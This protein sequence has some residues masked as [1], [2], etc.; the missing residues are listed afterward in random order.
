MK[1]INFH[2]TYTVG[3]RSWSGSYYGF[4][5][6]VIRISQYPGAPLYRIFVYDPDGKQI[7]NPPDI[8]GLRETFTEARRL[9]RLHGADTA[10]WEELAG[11]GK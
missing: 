2:E 9:L 1:K 8:D 10:R 5:A 7:D 4:R 6:D 3:A 11:D